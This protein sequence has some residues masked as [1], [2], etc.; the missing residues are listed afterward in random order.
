MCVCVCVWTD[1]L[2]HCQS[3]TQVEMKLWVSG[4]LFDEQMFASLCVCVRSL[5]GGYWG[6]GAPES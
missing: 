6:E 4:H 3:T 2:Q 5:G 1:W